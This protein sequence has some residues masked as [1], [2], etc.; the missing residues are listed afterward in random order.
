MTTTVTTAGDSAGHGTRPDDAAPPDG[1]RWDAILERINSTAELVLPA[2]AHRT[3]WHRVRATG[4][5]SSDALAVLGLSDWTTPYELWLDKTGQLPP[6]PSK[7]RLK[8]GQMLE[9][10]VADWFT[11][12][13]GLR[14]TST[15]TWRRRVPLVHDDEL[16]QFWAICNPDR[17]C[18]DGAGLEIKTVSPHSKDARLW[19]DM[20]PD[21]PEAQAQWHMAVTGLSA[22]WIAALMDGADAPN[23]HCVHRDPEVQGALLEGAADFGLHNVLARVAP[24]VDPRPSTEKAINRA[25]VVAGAVGEVELGHILDQL[26]ARRAKLKAEQSAVKTELTGVENEIKALLARPQAPAPEP[27][28]EGPKRPAAYEWGMVNGVRRVRFRQIHRSAYT[29]KEGDYMEL[30][31]VA[32]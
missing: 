23:I 9:P 8:W 17:L 2:G 19:K 16:G 32:A 25:A 14:V 6:T 27:D 13:T 10:V 18:E 3:D 5:G 15:G 24:P 11:E 22:W 21:Y 30:R 4:I 1:G 28:V 20:V 7:G 29:V 31:E 12:E 26:L